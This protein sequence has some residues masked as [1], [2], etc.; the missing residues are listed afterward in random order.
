M[1]FDMGLF[2]SIQQMVFQFQKIAIGLPVLLIFAALAWMIL[3]ALL[4]PVFGR[5]AGMV[6]NVCMWVFAAML[7]TNPTLGWAA[8]DYS[9]AVASQFIG[10]GGLPDIPDFTGMVNDAVNQIRG[11]FPF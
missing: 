1:Y 3:W 8:L 6:A 9:Y 4:T 10:T 7:L 2:D 11:A 5:F